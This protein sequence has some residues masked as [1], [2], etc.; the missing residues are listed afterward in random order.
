MT[1]GVDNV[2]GNYEGYYEVIESLSEL[3]IPQVVTLVDI[4]P[5]GSLC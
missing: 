4:F 3:G 2:I 1:W 5:Q